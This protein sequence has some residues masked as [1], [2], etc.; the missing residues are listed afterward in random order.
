MN[1]IVRKQSIYIRAAHILLVQVEH[2]NIRVILKDHTGY[3][4]VTYLQWLSGTVRLD[5][6]THLHDLAGAF[7]SQRYR[8]QAERISLK[9]M[10]V[11]SADAAA[12]YFYKDISVADLRHRKFLYIIMLQSRQHRYM[13]GLRN[14]LACCRCSCRG[15]NRLAQHAFQNLLYNGFYICRIH[16]HFILPPQLTTSLPLYCRGTS[17][18]S[19]AACSAAG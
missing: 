19:M 16:F 13:R 11:C 5:I 1:I 14:R 4:L 18:I 2:G 3:Y 6:L 7:M 12:F 10:S 15:R 9:F 8:D 17:L